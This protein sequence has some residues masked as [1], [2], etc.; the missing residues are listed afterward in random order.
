ISVLLVT[1][2][3]PS[4]GTTAF[5]M[6]SPSANTVLLSATPVPLVSSRMMILSLGI[7]P[8]TSCGYV[9]EVAHQSRPFESQF[10]WMG[11]SII[12]SDANRWISN[13]SAIL[14]LARSISGSGLGISARAIPPTRSATPMIIQGNVRLCSVMLFAVDERQRIG[15]RNRNAQLCDFGLAGRDH[16]FEFGDLDRVA[17]LFV[18][19]IPEDV[20]VVLRPPV[21]EEVEVLCDDELSKLFLLLVG[22]A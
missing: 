17:A 1:Y 9:C 4:P 22:R 5:G 6:N 16:R 3:P 20:G 12:G 8:G 13:P 10:I 19:A 2:A 7:W 18:F 21:V 14:K 11:F 15:V